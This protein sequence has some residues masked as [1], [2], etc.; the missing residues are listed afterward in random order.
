M[1][2]AWVLFRAPYCAQALK[3]YINMLVWHGYEISLNALSAA[4]PDGR[5]EIV[6]EVFLFIVAVFL[7]NSLEIVRYMKMNRK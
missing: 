3:M 2:F 5:K 1:N 4:M 6:V 7:P